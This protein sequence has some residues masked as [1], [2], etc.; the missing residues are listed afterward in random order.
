MNYNKYLIIILALGVF[1]VRSSNAQNVSF[2]FGTGIGSYRMNQLKEYTNTIKE[3]LVFPVEIVSDFPVY[4]NYNADLLLN[5]N[6]FNI[7]LTY[8]FQ[9]TGN[10]LSQGDYSGSYNLKMNV[11]SHSPGVRCEYLINESKIQLYISGTI[12]AHI[13]TMNLHEE[14][15]IFDQSESESFVFKSS[16]VFFEPGFKAL[17]PVKFINLFLF[18]GYHLQP[19]QKPLKLDGEDDMELTNPKT[20]NTVGLGWTGFRLRA[21]ISLTI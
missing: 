7:G 13:S 19:G 14:I 11:K 12:G 4:W 18:A 9:S 5:L 3:E 1:G 21:G 8:G 20:G 10:H 17:Y 2:S 6:K 16:D 15:V